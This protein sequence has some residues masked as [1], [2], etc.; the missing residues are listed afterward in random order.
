MFKKRQRL[1][2][3]VKNIKVKGLFRTTCLFQRRPDDNNG[4]IILIMS[5]CCSFYIFWGE[6]FMFHSPFVAFQTA[7]IFMYR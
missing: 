7:A 1:Y 5:V 3:S 6:L 2:F 4:T